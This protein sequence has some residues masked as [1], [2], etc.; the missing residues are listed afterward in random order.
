MHAALEMTALLINIQPG[1][2]VIMPSFT[3]V[4]CA[5][6]FVLRGA[7]IRFVDSNCNEPNINVSR[8][9]SL[10]NKKT[11]AIIAVHYAGNPCDM[12]ELN[13]NQKKILTRIDRRLCT[14][15]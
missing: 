13:K 14:C 15:N 2:E 1:D 3:F 4:S 9:E 8:I 12:D 6:A 11:K 5:N 10:V 7:I